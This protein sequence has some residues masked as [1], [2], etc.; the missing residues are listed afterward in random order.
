MI[1]LTFAQ[2][3]SQH[4]I[5]LS[6]YIYYRGALGVLDLEHYRLSVDIA[7]YVYLCFSGFMPNMQRNQASSQFASPQSGPPM[8]PHPSPA[9]PLYP[10]MGPYSQSGPSGPYGPQGSQYGHQG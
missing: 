5:L 10:G 9:G 6:G 3:L 8:S 7:F 4:L 1:P 2:F